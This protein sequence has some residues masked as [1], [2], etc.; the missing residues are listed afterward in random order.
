[1]FLDAPMRLYILFGT[2]FA[3]VVQVGGT[4][5][6]LSWCDWGI[7]MKLNTVLDLWVY[8]RSSSDCF[9]C[10]KH[11]VK[12]ITLASI[13]FGEMYVFSVNI[14]PHAKLENF[15]LTIFTKFATSL[16]KIEVS[17]NTVDYICPL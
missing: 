3:C 2:V 6:E 5:L 13:K 8:I 12:W 1:M 11:Y 9:V 17:H 10:D 16:I 7:K 4:L 14:G 15:Y